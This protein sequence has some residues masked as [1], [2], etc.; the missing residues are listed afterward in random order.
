MKLNSLYD[1]FVHELRDIYDAERQLVK[2]LRKMAKAASA[3]DLRNVFTE[4][5]S[6]T[7]GQINRLEAVFEDFDLKPKGRSCEAMKG[8]VEEGRTVMESMEDEA[9]GD[10][11]LIAAAQKVEHYEIASYG[12]LATW[13]QQLGHTHAARLLADTLAEEKRADSR[14]NALA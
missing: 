5:L 14:L 1:L 6:E 13:A 9:T 12:C 8:L 2:A 7:E 4:H 11:G 3:D 10:A